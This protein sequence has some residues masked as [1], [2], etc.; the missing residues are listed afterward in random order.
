MRRAVK[1]HYQEYDRQNRD[2]SADNDQDLRETHGFFG[3]EQ[4]GFDLRGV[5][6]SG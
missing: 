4:L 6:R 1:S 3:R 5:V 2:D